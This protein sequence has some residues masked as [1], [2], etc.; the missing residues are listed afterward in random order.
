MPQISRT[1][2]RQLAASPK[3]QAELQRR[4]EL[5][6][7]A[8]KA[9]AP[10]HANPELRARS[11]PGRPSGTLRDSLDVKVVRSS[12]SDSGFALRLISEGDSQ[13]LKYVRDGREAIRIVPK[14]TNKSGKLIF[15]DNKRGATTVASSVLSGRVKPNRWYLPLLRDALKGLRL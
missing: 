14:A 5:A 11:Y 1:A 15:F 6:L 4:A 3:F 13:V 9:A 10:V 2:L 12:T 8:V 7:I